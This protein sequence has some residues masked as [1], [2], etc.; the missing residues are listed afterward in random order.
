M[1]GKVTGIVGLWH[2]VSVVKQSLDACKLGARRSRILFA[3]CAKCDSLSDSGGR[4]LNPVF[5][6]LT[7]INFDVKETEDTGLEI[8]CGVEEEKVQA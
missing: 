7:G 2:R 5:V 1:D 6:N 8:L 4:H 3:Y